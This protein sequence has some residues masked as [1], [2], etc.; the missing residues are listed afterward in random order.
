MRLYRSLPLWSIWTTSSRLV[1][2]LILLVLV[3][4]FLAAVDDARFD[5]G[6]EAKF[7]H[8]G[9]VVCNGNRID[10]GSGLRRDVRNDELVIVNDWLAAGDDRLAIGDNRLV[11]DNNGLVTRINK[12]TNADDGSD[13]WA[14]N[15]ADIQ[16]S[17]GRILES[18]ALISDLAIDQMRTWLWTILGSGMLRILMILGQTGLK[19][20][21]TILL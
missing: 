13:A 14:G 7:V 10:A 3:L 15:Q 12:K 19:I 1:F 17:F 11:V 18:I 20:S 21:T 6:K 5:I 9:S 2:L 8:D 16:P 4:T